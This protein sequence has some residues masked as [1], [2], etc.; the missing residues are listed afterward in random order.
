MESTNLQAFAERVIQRLKD[1][2]LNGFRVI[3]ERHLDHI[4][5]IGADWYSKR[6]GHS[7]R[8]HLP[9]VRAEGRAPLVDLAKHKIICHTELGGYLKS[10]RAAA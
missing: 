10:Y 8:D 4:L 1:E 3:N 2:V 5:T 9:P 6:R 7:G